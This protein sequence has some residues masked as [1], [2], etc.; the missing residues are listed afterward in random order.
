[1]IGHLTG[2]II[3]SDTRSVVLDVNGVGYKVY[4]NTGMLDGKSDAKEVA[5]EKT[6]SFWTYLAVRETALDLYGFGTKDEL[7]FFELL[8]TISGIGPKSASNILALASLSSLRQAI[9]SGDTS[10]LTKI[11]G[12]GKKVADKI[13]LELK[14]K[15]GLVG[16]EFGT[17]ISGDVDALLALQSL[18]YSERDAR[19]A[20]KKSVGTTEE[21]V[22][23]ALKQ[24]SK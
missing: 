10:H 12:I 13:V 15:I 20:L 1:M 3:W 24:L 14:D 6:V 4:T 23:G 19:E 9:S 5:S 16:E 22:R 17:N 8:L 18:G 2:T 21:K 7:D 11:S